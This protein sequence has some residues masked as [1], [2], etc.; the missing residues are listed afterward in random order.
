MSIRTRTHNSPFYF[1]TG[2]S[3]TVIDMITSEVTSMGYELWQP[4]LGGLGILSHAKKPD[5]LLQQ[6]F[7][8]ISIAG[9]SEKLSDGSLIGPH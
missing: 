6:Q 3:Q 9:G 1:S 5:I 7:D 8:M 4:T 2:T